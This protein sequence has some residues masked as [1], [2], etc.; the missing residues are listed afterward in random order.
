MVSE[1]VHTK[2]AGFGTRDRCLQS[3]SSGFSREFGIQAWSARHMYTAVWKT[4]QCSIW[5]MGIQFV[6]SIVFEGRYL[7]ENV[8]VLESDI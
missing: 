1:M 4:N 2:N 3:T 7:R 5:G 8:V 6:Q